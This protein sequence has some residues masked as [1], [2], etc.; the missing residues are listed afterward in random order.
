[1]GRPWRTQGRALWLTAAGRRGANSLDPLTLARRIADEL[2]ERQ[3]EVI[4]LLDISQVAN[5][6]D[7][8]VIASAGSAR[9][10]EALSEAMKDLP[11]TAPPRR[12]GTSDSGWQ[13]F[14][15]GDVVVHLFSP[16]ERAYYNLEECWSAGRQLLRIE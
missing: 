1:M 10:F 13:L 3:A 6:T 8:F 14:D 9:Q 7:F 11:E 4:V 16:D 15:F 2:A 12:E 5:F